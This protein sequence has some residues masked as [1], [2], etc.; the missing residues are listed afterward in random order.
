MI[1]QDWS[2]L[3]EDIRNMVQDAIDSKDFRQ[4]N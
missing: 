2:N 3:G 1:N 4:L